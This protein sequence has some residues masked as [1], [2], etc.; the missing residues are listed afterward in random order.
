MV[1]GRPH[2]PIDEI[3]PVSHQEKPLGVLVQTARVGDPLRIIQKFDNI[4]IISLAGLG[5]HHAPWFIHCQ[6]NRPV[7]PVLLHRLPV[8]H[9]LLAL[10]HLHARRRRHPVDGHP[11]LPDQPVRF[12]PGAHPCFAQVFVQTYHYVSFPS[13]T[14]G[15]PAIT[16]LPNQRSKN[17]PILNMLSAFRY[18]FLRNPSAPV[19]SR[20]IP[21][22]RFCFSLPLS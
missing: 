3:S 19:R 21:S 8:Q 13:V 1:M 11:S 17:Q 15:I 2:H 9:H 7:L 14:A 12:S 6:Q 20:N 22:E 10:L 4:H 5:A 16:I 18:F